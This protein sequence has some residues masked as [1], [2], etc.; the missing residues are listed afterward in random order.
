MN[1]YEEA[2]EL[3]ENWTNGNRSFVFKKLSEYGG[4]ASCAVCVQLVLLIPRNARK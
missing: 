3:F 4:L 2:V 1:F